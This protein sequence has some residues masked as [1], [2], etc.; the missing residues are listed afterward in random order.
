M[1]TIDR[2]RLLRFAKRRYKEVRADW[3]EPGA[4]LR[5]QSLT[6]R[7]RSAVEKSM[8]DESSVREALIVAALVDDNGNRILSD[9]NV[10]WLSTLDAQAIA[11]IV[12]A[13]GDHCDLQ[14][15]RLNPAPIAKN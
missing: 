2:E 9:E 7:E 13:I 15:T 10:E 5:I 14:G 4:V 11:A 1:T 3:I 12:N 6:E 8:K